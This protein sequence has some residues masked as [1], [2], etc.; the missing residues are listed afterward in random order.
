MPKPVNS[1]ADCLACSPAFVPWVEAEP[2]LREAWRALP[3]RRLA[4]GAVLQPIGAP[5]SAVWFVERGLLRSHFADADG[6]ERNRAFHAEGQRAGAP[7]TSRPAPSAFAIEALEASTVIEPPH[8]ELLRW[9]AV[10][11]PARTTLLDALAAGVEQLARRE[12][13][14]LM[15]S[16]EARYLTFLADQPA[17]AQRVP[18][19]HIAS[20][21]GITDV[22]LSRIRRRL[23][24]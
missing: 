12:S 3:R 15:H 16:A 23:R 1:S 14:L 4:R 8:T 11:A 7:P 22:A 21:L 13:A 5:L 20:Y 18:L 24:A 19:R 6:L 17:L 2:A 10:H 9:Q